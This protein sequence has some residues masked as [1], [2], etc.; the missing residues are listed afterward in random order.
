MNSNN[1]F[2]V[3]L[4]N[5]IAMHFRLHSKSLTMGRDNKKFEGEDWMNSL[6]RHLGR[7][8]YLR[9]P[10]MRQVIAGSD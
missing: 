5:K 2:L 10:N 4:K 9:S 7:K 8:P 3:D 1:T 6:P